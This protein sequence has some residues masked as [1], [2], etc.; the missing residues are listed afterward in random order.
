MF[1]VDRF[2]KKTKAKTDKTM[3]INNQIGK[4]QRSLSEIPG[5]CQKGLAVLT[6]Q[7]S[8]V[9]MLLREG[10]SVTECSQR[11]NIKRRDVN[12]RVA[13]IYHKLNVRTIAELIIKYRER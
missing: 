4:V 13:G 7:E 1:F 12:R 5:V 8:K 6:E 11:L 3:P 10:F 9:F 2:R